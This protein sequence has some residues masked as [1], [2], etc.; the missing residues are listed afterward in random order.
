MAIDGSRSAFPVNTDNW[1]EESL[2]NVCQV[3]TATDWN[4][5]EHATYALERHNF[6][7]MQTGAAGVLTH[8]TSGSARPGILY[9]TYVVTLTGSATATKTARLS[10]F[11]TAE[12]NLFGGTP[13]ASGNL[14][15]L[16]V[17]RL[18]G[19]SVNRTFYRAAVQAPLNTDLSGDS[20]WWVSFSRHRN[21]NDSYDISAGTFVLTVCITSAST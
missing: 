20:G 2:N 18:P 10:G 16:S 3:L 19:D 15:H 21:I 9:K 11:T 8:A 1:G 13:L 5:V 17:R 14:V 4:K 6:G 12:K 7:I